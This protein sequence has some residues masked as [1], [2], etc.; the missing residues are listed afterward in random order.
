MAYRYTVTTYSCPH[1]K[2]VIKT[3]NQGAWTFFWL[4]LFPIHLFITLPIIIARA[5]I[6]KI[7][8]IEETKIGSP[9]NSCKHCGL[10]IKNNERIEWN[11]LKDEYKKMWSFRWLFRTAYII[12]GLAIGM[13][14]LSLLAG[15]WWSTHPSDIKT[16]TVLWVISVIFIITTSIIIYLWKRY[17]SL[18]H[19]TVTQGDY[20]LIKESNNRYKKSGDKHEPTKMTLKIF[21]TNQVVKPLTTKEESAKLIPQQVEDDDFE[22]EEDIEYDEDEEIDES[23]AEEE[24]DSI[25]EDEEDADEEEI[26]VARKNIKKD[27][28]DES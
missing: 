5:I 12:S 22:E 24:N 27:D 6:V 3:D 25:E 20:E 28:A 8:G 4:L 21:G 23:I 16:N 13:I 10:P 18:N 7:T 9:Y 26:I 14:I 17:K 2:R 1:C 15:G 19:I 11:S